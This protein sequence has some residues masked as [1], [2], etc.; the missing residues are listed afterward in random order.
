MEKEANNTK[1]SFLKKD[2]P[3]R[4]YYD[5]KIAEFAKA[6]LGNKIL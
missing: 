2:D 5:H 4:P 6:I 1:F 3:Y